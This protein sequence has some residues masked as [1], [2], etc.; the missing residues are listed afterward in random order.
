MEQFKIP[1]IQNIDSLRI[2]SDSYLNRKVETSIEKYLTKK[3]IEGR[4]KE[5]LFTAIDIILYRHLGIL[6]TCQEQLATY[7]YLIR[8]YS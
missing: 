3:I 2:L 7:S 6:L 8:L 5:N 1:T 4:R